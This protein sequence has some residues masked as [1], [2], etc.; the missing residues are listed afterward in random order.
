M[1]PAHRRGAAQVW[2]AEKARELGPRW[3]KE[4]KPCWQYYGA[5]ARWDDGTFEPRTAGGF[6]YLWK[7]KD[8]TGRW[9]IEDGRLVFVFPYIDTIS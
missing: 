5:F 2:N 3:F 8:V 9:R 6:H 1:A 4:G 7:N